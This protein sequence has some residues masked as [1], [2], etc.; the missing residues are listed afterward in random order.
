MQRQVQVLKEK[1]SAMSN[2]QRGDRNPDTIGITRKKRSR[3]KA[4]SQLVVVC[5][6]WV[7]I[8]HRLPIIAKGADNQSFMD[9]GLEEL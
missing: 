1:I 8:P 5:G 9:K 2:S 7:F 6:E 4:D 3:K